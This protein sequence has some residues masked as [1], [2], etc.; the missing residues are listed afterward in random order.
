M[1]ELFNRGPLREFLASRVSAVISSL[2]KMPED[3]VLARST[4]DLVEMFAERA[5]L[6]PLTIGSDAVDGGVRDGS[7]SV[8]DQFYGDRMVKRPVLH[9]H[10][11]YNFA[12]EQDLLF[13][14]PQQHLAYTRIAADVSAGT[15][16]VRVTVNAGTDEKAARRALDSEI[17][18]IRQNAGYS[19]TDVAAYNSSLDGRIRPAVERRKKLL[20]ER[21]DLAGALGFPMTRRSDAPAAV[22]LV[23]KTIGTARSRPPAGA[24]EPYRDE[25]ALTHAQYED[26]IA[27]VTSTLLAMERTPS[28][29][30]GKDEEELRDQI[31]VQ[32]NGTFEGAATGE[33]FVQSGKTDILLRVEDRH[34]F[35]A[36]CK[37]WTGEK[38]CGEALDQLLGYLPWRDEKAALILFI[39]RQDASAVIEK[40][41]AAVRAHSSFKRVGKATTDKMKRRNFIISHPDDRER[42]I[43]LA[44]LFAVLPKSA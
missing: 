14:Q 4:D 22:P 5:R 15:L 35:V 19:A 13:Y 16:I 7:V 30:S 34:V 37:W 28:V 26:A 25:P 20:Q 32:L 29:A 42:E 6:E 33:T 9:L 1:P 12:G 31:L 18:Q 38:A 8:R 27:V 3:E 23:R 40:A 44:V 24:R 2:E 39:D 11:M 43:H 36:E 17:G 21:R 10:A 41:D